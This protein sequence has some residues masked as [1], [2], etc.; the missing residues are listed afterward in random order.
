ML[1][2]SARWLVF[3]VFVCLLTSCSTIPKTSSIP[4]AFPAGLSLPAPNTSSQ[5]SLE[6]TLYQRRSI[7]DYQNQG[8]TLSEVAQLMWA[9]QGKTVEWGGRT[10]PSAGGLFPLDI[11]V[12]SGQVEGLAQGIYRYVAERH[13]LVKIKEGDFREQLYSAALKQNPVKN[14]AIDILVTAVYARTTV[15]YGERGVRYAWLEAGHAAQNIC[16]E[17]TALDLGA[18]TI[19]AFDDEQ[20]ARAAG[21]A[22]GET[23]LYIIPVGRM[24]NGR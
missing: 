11:Y 7:R 18:V 3:F 8:L 6:E 13:E 17:V 23:P 12:F 24:D 2:N 20:V 19:G 10:A 14:A 22:S 1:K 16:L 4:A 9:A 21:L 5:V 15:K